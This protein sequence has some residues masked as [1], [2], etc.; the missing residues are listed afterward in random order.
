MRLIIGVYLT[1]IALTA[2]AQTDVYLLIGQSNMAG[3]GFLTATD[4]IPTEGIRKL[5][6]FG[7]L[8]PAAEPL[9]FDKSTAGAGLGLSFAVKMRQSDPG[10]EVLL[11]PCAF[12]GTKLCEWQKGEYKYDFALLRVRHA[13]KAL[14][15]DGRLKGVLWH[16]GEWDS[17]ERTD[18]ETYGARLV[19]MITDL[20]RDLGDESVPIVLGELGRFLGDASHKNHYAYHGKVN[21]ELRR[22][23]SQ[24]KNCALVS[25]NG[26]TSNPDF[27]HFDTPSLRILGE[28][29]AEALRRLNK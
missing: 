26:L 20:R 24:L 29:Y 6:S 10:H 12:G 7:Y 22:A 9:H 11:V 25:S 17:V 19:R 16:Q 2:A 21:E 28:R 15:G 5:T 18:A 3:R 13:L 4:T 1:F 27:L 14:K 8:V 23:A